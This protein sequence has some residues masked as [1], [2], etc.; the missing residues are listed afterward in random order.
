MN[1]LRRF[2]LT[3]EGSTAIE[4]GE[5]YGSQDIRK[6][7]SDLRKQGWD[8]RSI[9]LD[10][11]GRKKY[12]LDFGQLHSLRVKYNYLYSNLNKFNN[13]GEKE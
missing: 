9:R 3:G 1:N 13:H 8:I 5:L 6:A 2:F 10:G 12:W 11:S 4:L 7:I